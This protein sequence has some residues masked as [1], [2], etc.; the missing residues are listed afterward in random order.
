MA[1]R[2]DEA[3]G[4]KP[5]PGVNEPERLSDRL[6]RWDDFRS[7]TVRTYVARKRESDRRQREG[8]P[9]PTR[10]ASIGEAAVEECAVETAVIHNDPSLCDRLAADCL[11]P[12]RGL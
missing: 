11:W 2:L 10:N 8:L 7:C 3:Y 9:R 12:S 6:A 5:L 4:N 1:A